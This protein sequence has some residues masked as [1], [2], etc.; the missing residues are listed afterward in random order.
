M[1]FP[2]SEDDRC[3][4]IALDEAIWKDRSPDEH[5]R[6]HHFEKRDLEEAEWQRIQQLITAHSLPCVLWSGPYG[7]L[8]MKIYEHPPFSDNKPTHIC[9]V[10]RGNLPGFSALGGDGDAKWPVAWDALSVFTHSESNKQ[11]LR[12]YR[13]ESP[14]ERSYY[15][16]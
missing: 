13:F 16:Y 6:C 9:T 4:L 8:R 12:F 1:N 11:A 2:L 7:E 10:G 15:E 3:W 14:R 5:G